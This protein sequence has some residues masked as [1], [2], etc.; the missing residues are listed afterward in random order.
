MSYR[1]LPWV[2]RGLAAGI[3]TPDPLTAAMPAHARFPVRLSLST[4]DTAAVDLRLSGPG[5]VIGVDPRVVVR[6]EPVRFARNFP[7]D[8]FAAVEFDP[9][10]FPWMFT[11]AAPGA[12]ERLRPWLVLV[13]VA[14]QRGVAIRVARDR[15]LPQLVIEPPTL[16]ADELPDLSESWAWAHAHV[17]ED[18]PPASV[19]DH[20]RDEPDLNVARV[21]CPR[22]LEPERDY[23]ACLVPAFEA[24]RLAGLGQDVPEA[25]TTAPAWGAGGSAGATVTLPLY[26]H[27]EFRTGPAGDFESLARR[28]TPRPVPDTVGFRRMFIGDAH[29]AL[30]ALP[31]D[32]G[33]IVHLEGALRSPEAGTGAALGPEHDPWVDDLVD[34]LDAPADHEVH[35]ASTDAESVAPPIYGGWHVKV[36]ALDDAAPDWLVELNTDPRHRAAAGLGTEV[37]RINQERF[38]QA[39][40]AQ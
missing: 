21:L 30:P 40:W 22:R 36:H 6:T 5:D 33:G 10:D 2:R 19:P 35:G 4:G 38:M 23:L 13:V 37:V 14:A 31:H 3:G 34:V 9:P 8:Q 27:W 16:P 32:A 24:G 12:Q 28:L 7:P 25:P 29:P 15:P 26:L 17:V 11:P 18:A 20:L 39:A 1:F